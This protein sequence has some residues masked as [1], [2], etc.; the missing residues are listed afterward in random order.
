MWTA[1]KP[2]LTLAREI[3]HLP[4]QPSYKYSTTKAKLY[5][6]CTKLWEI[7]HYSAFVL[8][9]GFADGVISILI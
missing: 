8:P 9:Y 4:I 1:Y 3:D 7:V 5:S 2:S 6:L